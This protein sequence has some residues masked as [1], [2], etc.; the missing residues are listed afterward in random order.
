M[1]GRFSFIFLSLPPT[2]PPYP[3]PSPPP[4]LRRRS[5]RRKYLSRGSS[6]R[7][8]KKR[9]RKERNGVQPEC[10]S[11]EITLGARN[12]VHQNPYVPSSLPPPLSL[13]LSL[14]LSSIVARFKPRST[15]GTTRVPRIRPG[16][17]AG[18][19]ELAISD[20]VFQA[21]DS[22]PRYEI[23]GTS[24][25]SSVQFGPLSGTLNDVAIDIG[26]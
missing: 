14:S 6:D 4:P 24:A 20:R 25:V 17:R 1:D 23:H 11:E 21:E 8:R 15:R 16:G 10:A 26:R 7:V 9:R 19:E 22:C 2:S 3:S 13:S 18:R 5:R 12:V